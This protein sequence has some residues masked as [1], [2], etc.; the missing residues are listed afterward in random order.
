M[1][2]FSN[3]YGDNIPIGFD[4]EGN[5]TSSNGMVYRDEDDGEGRMHQAVVGPRP[6]GGKERFFDM[7]LERADEEYPDYRSQEEEAYHFA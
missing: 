3:P 7:Q 6:Y 2:K 5:P 1:Y 4:D